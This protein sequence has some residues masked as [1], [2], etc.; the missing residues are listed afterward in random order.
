MKVENI[1]KEKGK[2]VYT[3]HVDAIVVDKDKS[4]LFPRRE[5]SHSG[6]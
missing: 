4:F 1:L 5:N 6:R 3:V 2:D